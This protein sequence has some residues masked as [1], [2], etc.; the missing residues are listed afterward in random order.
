MDGD[1]PPLFLAH[2][3]G[4]STHVYRQLVALLDPGQPVYGLERFDDGSVTERAARYVRLIRERHPTGPYRLGGW[5]FGG[6]LAFEMGRQ[7]A[8]AGEKVDSVLLLDSGLPVPVP[9]EE[10]A[11]LLTGR[12]T[13]F[14]RYLRETYQA[15]VEWDPDRL[16]QLPEDEQFALVLERMSAAGLTAKLPPAV[17]RHQIDSHRDT[18]ALDRYEAGPYPGPVTLYRC[19]QP[20]PWAVTDPRYEHPDAARGWDRF[21][22][23]LRIVPV[24]AHH[25]NMLDPPAVDVI[26]ADLRRTL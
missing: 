18:R 1:R 19:T 11:R 20:T 10:A 17:W 13:G 23:D 26:A 25:L 24:G 9:P 3:A 16:R 2:P 8:A 14:L 12:F 6:V 5:S 7:L 21:C 15:P 4:G 22:T